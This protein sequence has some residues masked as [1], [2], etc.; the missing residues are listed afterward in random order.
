[1]VR[2]V[3]S[4]YLLHNASAAQPYFDCAASHF[5]SGTDS[6]APESE[7]LLVAESM[8]D[9]PDNRKRPVMAS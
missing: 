3:P 7:R 5:P 9:T 6:G 1:M 2:N 4:V 8:V